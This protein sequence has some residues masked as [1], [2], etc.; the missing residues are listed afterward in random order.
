MCPKIRSSRRNFALAPFS[1]EDLAFDLKRKPFEIRAAIARLI[2]AGAIIKLVSKREG[3]PFY[4]LAGYVEPTDRPDNSEI[5]VLAIV[6]LRS[7]EDGLLRRDSY[8]P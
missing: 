1:L 7:I 6:R 5:P 8:D 4:A 3:W 2:A